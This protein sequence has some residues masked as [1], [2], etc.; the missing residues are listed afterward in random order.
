MRRSDGPGRAF[1]RLFF[2]RSKKRLAHRTRCRKR[3]VAARCAKPFHP[4]VLIGKI[5]L[6][7]ARLPIRSGEEP[8]SSLNKSEFPGFLQALRL[9]ISALGMT[10]KSVHFMRIGYSKLYFIGTRKSQLSL[11]RSSGIG[12]LPLIFSIA[13]RA[14]WSSEW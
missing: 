13:F 5:E 9:C 8:G 4:T 3:I 7:L 11:C 6:I 12:N 10:V 1:F 14:A 2:A